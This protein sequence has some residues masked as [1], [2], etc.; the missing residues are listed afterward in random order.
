MW[1]RGRGLKSQL[2]RRGKRDK[3]TWP[4]LEMLK[5]YRIAALGAILA[6]VIVSAGFGAY[7][8]AFT[9]NVKETVQQEDFRNDCSNPKSAAGSDQCAQ[10]KAA[11]ASSDAARWAWW[12][13]LVGFLG[14]IGLGI[15]LVFNIRALQA[16]ERSARVSEHALDHQKEIDV[17]SHRAYVVVKELRLHNTNPPDGLFGVELIYLN[18]GVT[19]ARNV[20]AQHRVSGIGCGNV[21]T[22]AAH[23]EV[24][25]RQPGGSIGVLPTGIEENN[26]ALTNGG[27]SYTEV[28]EAVAAGQFVVFG[29]G[30]ITYEDVFGVP[31]QTNYQW[32][33][34]RTCIEKRVGMR[35][36]EHGNSM[37]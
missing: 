15:T 2:R 28:Y 10:W 5:Q 30:W 21:Q 19:P 27:F 13:L 8:T 12:Q 29:H 20:Y 23:I 31:R 22:A 35:V 18:Q 17:L 36:Y 14:T 1:Q 34:D 9:I 7:A 24:P 3:Q 11:D 25:E 33:F 32:F 4:H 37:A 26:V 6:L 16:A